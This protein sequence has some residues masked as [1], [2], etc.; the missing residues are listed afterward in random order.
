[1][2]G[3]LIMVITTLG[4]RHLEINLCLLELLLISVQFGSVI[5]EEL[6]DSVANLLHFVVVLIQIQRG[7]S[8]E[9]ARFL[10]AASYSRFNPFGQNAVKCLAFL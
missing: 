3:E 9:S 4:Q 1:M 5:F 2:H 7:V 6:N 10:L 8:D